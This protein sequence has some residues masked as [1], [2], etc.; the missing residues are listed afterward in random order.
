LQE[1]NAKN[2]KILY[3]CGGAQIGD[4]IPPY[5]KN[6]KTFQMGWPGKGRIRKALSRGVSPHNI[7]AKW[8]YKAYAR[9]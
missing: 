5:A 8:F 4:K 7:I 6:S 9:K 2:N 3:M 1:K